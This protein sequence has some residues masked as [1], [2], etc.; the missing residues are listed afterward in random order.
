M[1]LNLPSWQL[2]VIQISTGHSINPG[3]VFYT[4]LLDLIYDYLREYFPPEGIA[5]CRHLFSFPHYY[6]DVNNSQK[7][8]IEVHVRVMLIF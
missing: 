4:E 6:N 2:H 1:Q 7:C 5:H 3:V 8:F